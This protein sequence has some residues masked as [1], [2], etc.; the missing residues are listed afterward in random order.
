MMFR[1][2]VVLLL[3]ATLFASAETKRTSSTVP[4]ERPNVVILYADDMGYGDFSANESSS[5]IPTPNFDKLAA[6]GVRFTDGHSSSGICS[7]SC[8]AL[9]TGQHHWRRFFKI[10]DSFGP[11]VFEKGEY[12]L[13]KMFGAKGYSTAAIGKWHLGWNWNAVKKPGAKLKNV[14]WDR[15]DGRVLM[16]KSYTVNAIDW[17]KP[18]PGGPLDQGFD[19]YFGDG[20]INFPPYCFMENDRVLEVP[21][22]MADFSKFEPVPEGDWGSRPGPV[23]VGWNPYNVL[24][25]ITDKAVEWI[26]NQ[27]ADK[28]FFLYFAFP[29]PHEP[30][31]PNKEYRGKSQA[32]P[33]GDFVF[34]S[35]AM[36]GRIMQALETGGF[37]ENTIVI[38]TADNGAELMAYERQ[39]IYGHW[40][41][42]RLR[43]VKRDLWEGGHR[44]PFVIKWP[45]VIEPG[46][47]SNETINQV[48]L[49][50]TFAR[51]IGYGLNAEEAID[52]YDLLPLLKGEKYNQ[53]LRNA[54]VQNTKKG[55][56]ALRQGDWLFIN[57]KSGEH[58]NCPDW[59]NKE[60][61]YETGKT[62]GLLYNLK[63][64][65]AE[66]HN[67]YADY[68]ER[69]AQMHALLKRYVDGEGCAPRACEYVKA[70]E[71][72][73]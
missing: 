21:T 37:Y 40:S 51:I 29:S 25:T 10:V 31:V 11:S 41:S 65:P 72:I 17:M 35:D 43:G 9:L 19:Y 4:A 32:G 52:S 42:G 73:Q 24:P 49:A 34:E 13:P 54:T 47:V 12:T 68:P 66:H 8:F 27:Q 69:A 28:P 59:F 1:I 6:E 62:S 16:R 63:E 53:P 50:A 46:T 64:D 39:R 7:P 15:P 23:A 36:A 48:D 22:E 3:G 44:V 56:Y 38:F 67:L 30:V 45:R 58:S 61:G 33:Y 2:S 5:K 71:E 26:G 57:T 18:V 70:K 14:R 55:S 60:R 20:T